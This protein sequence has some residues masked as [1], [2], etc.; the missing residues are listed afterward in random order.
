MDTFTFFYH[1]Y[2]ASPNVSLPNYMVWPEMYCGTFLVCEQLA[3]C[4]YIKV[5]QPEVK[6]VSYLFIEILTT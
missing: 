4:R 2:P 3:H 6:S 5:E 1:G